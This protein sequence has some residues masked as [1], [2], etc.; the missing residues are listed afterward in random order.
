MLGGRTLRIK[1]R[2]PLGTV[3]GGDQVPTRWVPRGGILSPLLWLLR[4]NRIVEGAMAQLKKDISLPTASWDVVA[5][6]FADDISAA[7][8][9]EQ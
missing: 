6:I 1:L 7:I 5:Q 9:H 3:Y 2:T 4:V 8:S